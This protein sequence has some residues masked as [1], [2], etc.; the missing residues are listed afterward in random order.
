MAISLKE[1]V[2]REDLL[3][4]GHRACTGCTG[5]NILRQIMLVAGKNT[6]VGGA[7]GCMEVVTTIYPYTA[8]KT[9]FIHSAF[10]NVA[11]T[12][13]GAETAYR[14]LK[15]SG[16]LTEAADKAE[17]MNFIAFA[18]DGGTY[19]IG[20]QSL[21]GAMERATAAPTTS[22]CSRCRGP[23]SAVTTWCTCATITAR[24]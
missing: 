7:T 23:W 21:S 13:S 2:K 14:A 3:T 8:W 20:L 11:A 12:I 1:L 22:V 10:E 16:E 5:S 17:R 15:K 19:D 9:S 18:G 24:T 6:V 4:G